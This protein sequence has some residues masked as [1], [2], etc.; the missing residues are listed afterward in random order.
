MAAAVGRAVLR[1]FWLLIR[2]GVLREEAA[3]RLG[4]D[5]GTGQRWFS[6]AGGVFPAYVTAQPSGRYL[7]FAEREEIFAGVERGDSIR[8]IARSVGRAPST[9]RQ[10]LRR[11]MRHQL[12][13]ARHHR[14]HGVPVSAPW[15]YRPSWAQS[16]A[17]RMA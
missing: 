8:L 7:S 13:R 5:P 9:V 2:E 12:Y 17:E 3:T 11:N 14:A 6:Q 16:R 10:E 15:N 4:Y 1:R